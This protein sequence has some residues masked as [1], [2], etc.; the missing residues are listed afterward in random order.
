MK[1]IT[2]I[3]FLLFALQG[4]A[5]CWFSVSAGYVHTAAVR[6]DGTLWTWGLN[7]SGEL[8]LGYNSTMEEIPM[9]VGTGQNWATVSA[10]SEDHTVGLK[11][12]GTMWAWGSNNAGQLGTGN[13]TSTN[14]P[15]QIGTDSWRAVSCGES[16]TVAIKSD[17]TLWSFG[18]DFN[19]K[20]GNGAAGGQNAPMQ[21]GTDNN[22]QSVSAGIHHVIATKSDGTLWVWGANGS[23]QLGTGNYLESQIPVQI[24]NGSFWTSISAGEAFSA[25]IKLDRTLWTWGNNTYGQ[26]GDGT[27]VSKNVP[28]LVA[29][30]DN[31][32]SYVE[33]GDKHAVALK[34]DGSIW[35]WGQNLRGQLA[36]GTHQNS[37]APG[38]IGTGETYGVIAA[39]GFHTMAIQTNNALSGGGQNIYGQIGVDSVSDITA[40]TGVGCSML[41]VD[42]ADFKKFEIYPN[43]VKQ[44]LNIASTNG[45]MVQKIVVADISGKVIITQ[46]EN[47]TNIDV[48]HLQAGIY[49]VR[50]FSGDTC[51][52]NKIIKE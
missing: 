52:T 33:A 45:A 37:N 26:M 40:L 47:F 27:N 38:Q 34:W 7:T 43:P 48:A 10:G 18:S 21:I 24:G 11:I 13:Y 28:T 19:G 6:T 41:A 17:N 44:Q 36:N 51:Q 49:F 16:F 20:L 9:Q 14:V 22:W 42:I 39:G 35:T 8:G 50:L 23:G 15:V 12:D 1:K 4:K 31:N 25:A 2:F 5:Q 30:A 29:S 46:I 32:W 3:L